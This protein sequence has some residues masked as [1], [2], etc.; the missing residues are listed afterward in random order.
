MTV[1]FPNCYWSDISHMKAL[2]ALQHLLTCEFLNI[3]KYSYI[4]FKKVECIHGGFNNLI[5]LV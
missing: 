3:V 4:R 1:T 5:L 2:S